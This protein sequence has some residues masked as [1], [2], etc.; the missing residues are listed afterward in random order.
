MIG[1]YLC[2]GRNETP[3]LR[4]KFLV[5]LDKFSLDSQYS[6]IGLNGGLEYVSSQIYT[7]NITPESCESDYYWGDLLK[8]TTGWRKVCERKS[9]VINGI[10]QDN[11]PPYYVVS[12]IMFRQ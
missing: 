6:N 12:Y 11:R 2:D 1:W 10:W 9:G 3:D 8:S 4:G 5:G 7:A